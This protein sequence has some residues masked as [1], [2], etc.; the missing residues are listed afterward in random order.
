M[1]SSILALDF[2]LRT[3]NILFQFDFILSVSISKQ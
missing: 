2:V 1:L 3:G